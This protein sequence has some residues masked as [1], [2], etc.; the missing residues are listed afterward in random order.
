MRAV[1]CPHPQTERLGAADVQ[2]ASGSRDLLA[3]RVRDLGVKLVDC[4][5]RV[6]H[7][8]LSGGAL[9]AADCIT[10]QGKL[11]AVPIGKLPHSRCYVWTAASS[12]LGVRRCKSAG[13]YSV[14]LH[15]SEHQPQRACASSVH[16]KPNQTKPTETGVR[17]RLKTASTA[18]HGSRVLVALPT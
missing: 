8:C 5:Y 18:V 10:L 15:N 3:G 2:L 7:S 4:P 6:A 12:F 14:R 16:N 13:G 1:R 9:N 11:S 17:G